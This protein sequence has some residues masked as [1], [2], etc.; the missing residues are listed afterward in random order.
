M[1]LYL[2][3]LKVFIVI[4]H[5]INRQYYERSSVTRTSH[6]RSPLPLRGERGEKKEKNI[7]LKRCFRSDQILQRANRRFPSS[8][9]RYTSTRHGSRARAHSPS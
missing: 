2:R 3:L 9:R 7:E 8:E 1:N 6:S 5:D 4:W